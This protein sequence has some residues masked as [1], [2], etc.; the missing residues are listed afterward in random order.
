MVANHA[1]LI[2]L[3]IVLDL[4]L[5]FGPHL[6]VKSLFGPALADVLSFLKQ[7]SAAEMQPM[8]QS[9]GK[10]WDLFL[11][12]Y[13]LLSTLST[14]P[15]GIP[16]QMAVL[17]PR[18]TPLGSASSIEISS[19]GTF[20]LGWLA[21]TLVGFI[22]GSLY[23]AWVARTVGEGLAQNVAFPVE[24]LSKGSMPN[25]PGGLTPALIKSID[26]GGVPPL[27]LGT[28][29]W[30]TMQ[31]LAMMI[32][33]LGAALV[34]MVPV[35]FMT[36]VVALISPVVAQFVLILVLFS[37]V[38]ALIPLVFSPHGVFLCGQSVLNAIVNSSRV[39]RHS[40]PGTGLFL[41]TVVLLNQGLG[42]LW[43]SP[44]ENSWLA[45]VG[46]F[47]HAF[48]STGLLAAS[49]FYY[50]SGLIYAQALRKV[51]YRNV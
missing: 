7:S 15:V 33:L 48:I 8:L 37:A 14:F 18:T 43:N 21:L 10:L 38:W 2:L 1:Y 32:L 44:P 17:M 12:Q 26:I 22:L 51:T 6:R 49:F 13:N 20:F 34:L 16:A 40:L 25:N 23:F 31:I 9:M 11:E 41:L 46:I 29:G 47:G 24:D 35:M 45:L 19:F 3:P 50:R 28:L 30:Q 5:W 36:T 39:V 42:L 27:R 4:L